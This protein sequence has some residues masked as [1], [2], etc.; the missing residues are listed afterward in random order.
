MRQHRP[1]FM[2]V[3]QAL[4]PRLKMWDAIRPL[5]LQVY[6]G[7]YI[8]ADVACRRPFTPLL[9]AGVK[10]L[11]RASWHEV[12]CFLGR[13]KARITKHLVYH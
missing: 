6:G 5:I 11:L 8:D 13:K 9:P 4:T 2:A 7:V 12:R 3:W 1:G 10:V